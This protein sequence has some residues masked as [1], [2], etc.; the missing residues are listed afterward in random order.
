MQHRARAHDRSICGGVPRP[1][2]AQETQQL[3]SSVYNPTSGTLRSM[4]QQANPHSF[5]SQC[6]TLNNTAYVQYRPFPR[7]F[8]TTQEA[9]QLHDIILNCICALQAFQTPF[10]LVA[11]Y[12]ATPYVSVCAFIYE[13]FDKPLPLL[14]A[15]TGFFKRLFSQ[16]KA[17]GNTM[18]VQADIPGPP[19]LRHVEPNLAPRACLPFLPLH[20]GRPA[21]PCVCSRTNH[22]RPCT[23]L[24]VAS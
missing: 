15:P 11:G 1:R 9:R 10:S 6:R 5:S 23:I 8:L 18:C 20:A 7:P 12:L 22:T 16:R 21:T 14:H 4:F 19:P 2:G 24:A 3:T 17:P 13:R